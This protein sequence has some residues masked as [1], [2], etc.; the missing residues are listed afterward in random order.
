VR[1]GPRGIA[2]HQSS[3]GANRKSSGTF[4]SIVVGHLTPNPILKVLSSIRTHRVSALLT[5]GQACVFY[6]AAE[7]SRDTDLAILANS[8]NLAKLKKAIEDLQAVVIAVPPFDAKYL[9]KG[10]SSRAAVCRKSQ[11]M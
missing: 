9:R 1:N 5:G 10:A 3:G 7:F 4:I 8:E 2:Y 11:M 6:G